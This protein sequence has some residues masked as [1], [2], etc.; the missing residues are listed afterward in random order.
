[1]DGQSYL[2][3]SSGRKYRPGNAA[4]SKIIAW[5]R[6]HGDVCIYSHLGRFQ[7]GYTHKRWNKTF[8]KGYVMVWVFVWIMDMVFFLEAP[9]AGLGE[10]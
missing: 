1:M 8:G 7:P 2:R 6:G 5:Y 3:A 9:R 10:F 4:G